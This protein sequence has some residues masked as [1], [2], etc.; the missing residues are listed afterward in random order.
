MLARLAMAFGQL[1]IATTHMF[2]SNILVCLWYLHDIIL[3]YYDRVFIHREVTSG[4]S[5]VLFWEV[6]V[7]SLLS[8]EV[9]LET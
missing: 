7:R 1:Y 4:N 9:H 2:R 6:Q 5:L 8:L 3:Q